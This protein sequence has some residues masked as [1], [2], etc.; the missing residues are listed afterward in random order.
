MEQRNFRGTNDAFHI[1]CHSCG[2]DAHLGSWDP[3]D[4]EE[5]LTNCP[6]CGDDDL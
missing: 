4:G 5:E 6:Y 1:N 3:A 2:A